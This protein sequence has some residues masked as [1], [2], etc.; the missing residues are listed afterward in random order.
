MLATICFVLVSAMDKI[1]FFGYC[2][3]TDFLLNLKHLFDYE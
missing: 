1:S 2:L 3:T